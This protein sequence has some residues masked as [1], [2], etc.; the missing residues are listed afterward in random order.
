M[1]LYIRNKFISL[2]GSSTVKDEAGRDVFIVKGKLITVTRKK[3]IYDTNK[4]LLYTV[5]NKWFNIITHNAFIYDGS[6]TKIARVKRKFGFRNQF[7]VSGYDSEISVEGDF[8]S[9][10]LDIFR[11][12]AP[13]GTIRRQF[14]FTD[15]FVLETD[16]EDDAAFMVALVIAID[17]II[18]NLSSSSN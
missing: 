2:R 6:G 10:T 8:L 1:K 11:D 14:D 4:N 9:W 5:R 15:S 18:D 13:I 7:V 12:G 16:T 17:N 3:R